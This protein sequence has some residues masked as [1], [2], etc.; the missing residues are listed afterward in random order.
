MRRIESAH[1]IELR[2]GLRGSTAGRNSLGMRKMN[3]VVFTKS[4]AAISN[5]N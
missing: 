2:K 4:I 3:A 5:L 1:F